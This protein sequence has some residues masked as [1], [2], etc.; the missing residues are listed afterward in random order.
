MGGNLFI[1]QKFPK[2]HSGPAL[3]FPP[4]QSYKRGASTPCVGRVPASGRADAS[5]DAMLAISC[6]GMSPV[7]SLLHTSFPA[8]PLRSN[9]AVW[10]T[11]EVQLISRNAICR[12]GLSL[13]ANEW[14][15]VPPVAP[16]QI[17]YVRWL[18]TGHRIEMLRMI[19]SLPRWQLLGQTVC[20]LSLCRN[21][22]GLI[23]WKLNNNNLTSK[24]KKISEICKS[25]IVRA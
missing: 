8:S 18:I 3:L 12:T 16:C 7:G 11:K 13:G 20:H 22:W 14:L 21:R 24:I 25:Y 23:F 5:G 10:T 15:Q 9:L 17:C 6:W 2:F 1:S 19:C 4:F